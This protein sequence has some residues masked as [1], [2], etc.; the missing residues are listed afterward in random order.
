MAQ[1]T[2]QKRESLTQFLKYEGGDNIILHEVLSA[3]DT[4]VGYTARCKVCNTTYHWI[5][6]FYKDYGVDLKILGDF[7]FDHR[8][9]TKYQLMQEVKKHG[10]KITADEENEIIIFAGKEFKFKK[11]SLDEIELKV[12]DAKEKLIESVE[13]KPLILP[14]SDTKSFPLTGDITVHPGGK[15]ISSVSVSQ[16]LIKEVYKMS[17]FNVDLQAKVLQKIATEYRAVCTKCNGT[18]NIDYEELISYDKTTNTW[19]DLIKF[20]NVH[21]HKVNHEGAEK[22]RKFRDV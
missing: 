20:C 12:K 8:H 9:M 6:N 3:T 14:K 2:S 18:I 5:H 15:K 16:E 10:G 21:R 11:E 7:A 22:G 13:S 4:A 19:I 1:L 17:D